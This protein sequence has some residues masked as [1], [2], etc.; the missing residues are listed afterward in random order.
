MGRKQPEPSEEYLAEHAKHRAVYDEP[1]PTV[2]DGDVKP[3][4]NDER[5]VYRVV[6]RHE[7]FG[8]PT[9][10]ELELTDRQAAPLLECG[11]IELVV[12]EEISEPAEAESDDTGHL[13]EVNESE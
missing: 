12:A 7:V 11:H 3:V 5:S 8:A 4:E 10:G 2:I 6:G 1:A 13:P 9:G